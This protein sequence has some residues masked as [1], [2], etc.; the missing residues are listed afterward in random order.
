MIQSDPDL[1]QTQ[2]TSERAP[3]IVSL[4]TELQK[5]DRVKRIKK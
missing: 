5:K 3:T 1:K 2:S 4:K